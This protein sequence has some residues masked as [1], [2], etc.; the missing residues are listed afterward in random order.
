MREASFD[1]SGA[2]QN[3]T[4]CASAALSGVR[5][6]LN[7]SCGTNRARRKRRQ[8]GRPT[9]AVRRCGPMRYCD[10]RRCAIASFRS[11]I[12]PELD[13]NPI[14]NQERTKQIETV[15]G[16]SSRKSARSD[17]TVY[18]ANQARIPTSG[19]CRVFR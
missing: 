9:N 1:L 4:F 19:R 3:E 15:G 11:L 16:F 12:A 2:I 10:N 14:C 5:L 17:G 18:A 13:P 6:D 7:P 8:V